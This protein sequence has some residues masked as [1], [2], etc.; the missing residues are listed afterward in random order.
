[1]SLRGINAYQKGSLKQDLSA[2]SPHR[3]T[4]LL[5]QG[6]L[7]KMAYA[8]G[9]MERKDFEAKSA[10]ITKVSSILIYLRD[11]LN[12]ELGGEISDNLYALYTYMIEKVNEAHVQNISAPLDEAYSLLEP[13][14]DAWV[15]IPES[16][17]AVTTAG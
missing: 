11:T 14:R 6:A 1:M 3:L 12:F 7:D 17:Q 10:N 5:M 13:I 16:E 2:A 8:K 4:L 15:R 9:A